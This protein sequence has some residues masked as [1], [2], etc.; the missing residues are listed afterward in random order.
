[1]VIDDITI[2]YDKKLKPENPGDPIKIDARK[3]LF[4]YDLNVKNAK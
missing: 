1:M 2:W 4:S 3:I